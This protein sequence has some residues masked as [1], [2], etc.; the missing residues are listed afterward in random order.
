MQSW[1]HGVRETLIILWAVTVDTL[2]E[3]WQVALTIP[4]PILALIGA[5]IV[6]VILASRR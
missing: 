1:W 4:A 5:G 3:Y 6:A 2:R